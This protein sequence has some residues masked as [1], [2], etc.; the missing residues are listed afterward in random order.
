MKFEQTLSVK[1]IDGVFQRNFL[2]KYIVE[3]EDI[4]QIAMEYY[5]HDGNTLEDISHKIYGS[6]QY[7]W[8]IMIIN[9][10]TNR[11]NDWPLTQQELLQYIINSYGIEGMYDPHHYI[12]SLGNIVQDE[13][14]TP[15]TNL[16]YEE[17]QNDLKRNIYIPTL[18]FL[19]KFKKEVYREI[20]T[21][22]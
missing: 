3:Y 1:L 15:I 10:M 11:N 8:I 5:I 16:E 21:T 2:Q 4:T 18:E 14:A 13:S 17:T 12:D 20:N 22:L 9:T 19:E 6:S 7:E